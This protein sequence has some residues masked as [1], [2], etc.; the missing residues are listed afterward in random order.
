MG[1]A[2]VKVKLGDLLRR[3]VKGVKMLADTG[4]TCPYI[5]RELA[6]E[7]LL[8]AFALEALGLAVDPTT[9]EVKPTK[10]FIARA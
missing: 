10:G 8:V 7:P 6:E 1:H 5:P 9:G 2:Y 4:A 3:R